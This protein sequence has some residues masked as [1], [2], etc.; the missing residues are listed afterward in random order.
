LPDYAE[1][2]I[3]VGIGSGGISG[4]FEGFGNIGH[5]YRGGGV[6]AGLRLGF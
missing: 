2:K 3:G 1:G 6:R 5:A 4:F